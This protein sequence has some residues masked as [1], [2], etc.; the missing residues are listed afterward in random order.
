MNVR[1]LLAGCASIAVLAISCTEP[2]TQ[3]HAAT[4]SLEQRPGGTYAIPVGIGTYC[5]FSFLLDTGASDVAVSPELFRAMVKEGYI[6]RGDLRGHQEYITASGATMRA[7]QFRMP[8][9]SVGGYVVRDVTGSVYG[10]I[11]SSQMLLG[12]SFLSKLPPWSIDYTR[13]KFIF[14]YVSVSARV[15]PEALRRVDDGP[16]EL[17]T[18]VALVTGDCVYIPGVTLVTKE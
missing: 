10:G 17:C 1:S 13:H 6:R 9:M 11:G 8:P 16:I 15:E 2:V 7:Q 4:V 12:Q 5:C 3:Q 18:A 14:N